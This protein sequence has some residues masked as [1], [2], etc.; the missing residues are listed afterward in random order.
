[1][2][3][4]KRE[5]IGMTR[6]VAR[7]NFADYTM[8]DRLNELIIKLEFENALLQMKKDKMMQ[9]EEK[10]ESEILT[11]QTMILSMRARI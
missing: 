10:L 1:M 5:V 2:C 11:L 4:L 8:T 9:Y 7:N 6:N 3:V